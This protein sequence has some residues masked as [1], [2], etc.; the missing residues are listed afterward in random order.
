MSYIQE[1]LIETIIA[2]S[3]EVLSHNRSEMKKKVIGATRT[4]YV[5]MFLEHLWMLRGLPS[6]EFR[7][8]I[9]LGHKIDFNGRVDMS[10]TVK[11]QICKDLRIVRKTLENRISSLKKRELLIDVEH[12]E[13]EVSPFLFFKGDFKVVDQRRVDFSDKCLKNRKV[14]EDSN[15]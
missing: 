9:E 11:S 3:G 8:M 1:T 10:R 6:G 12:S 13:I 15:C 4:L 5:V 2:E 14:I 7:L